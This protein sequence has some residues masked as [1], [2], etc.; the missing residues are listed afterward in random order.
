MPKKK[1]A[2]VQEKK[3]TLPEALVGLQNLVTQANERISVLSQ[4][5]LKNLHSTHGLDVCF[6]TKTI[7]EELECDPALLFNA[8]TDSGPLFELLQ[9]GRVGG[10]YAT[11]KTTD[12]TGKS[13]FLRGGRIEWE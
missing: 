12:F 10:D 3:E 2:K 1:V 4:E 5:V 11:D 9:E 8:D 6:D 7:A 13:W